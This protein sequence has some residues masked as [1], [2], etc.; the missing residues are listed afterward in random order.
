MHAVVAFN[1]NTLLLWWQSIESWTSCW[2]L[3]IQCRLLIRF[4][5]AK[6]MA[7]EK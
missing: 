6:E 1:V 2:I 4:W 3:Q 7:K 5:Q